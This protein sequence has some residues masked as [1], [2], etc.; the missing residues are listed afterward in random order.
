MRALAANVRPPRRAGRIVRTAAA[1]QLPLPIRLGLRAAT[2]RPGRFVANTLGLSISIAMVITGLALHAGV[3]KHLRRGPSLARAQAGGADDPD[4]VSLAATVA[5]FDRLSTLVFACA[6]F[7]LG[8]AAVNAAVAAV[9]AA[10]DSARNHAILRTIGVTPRQTAAAFLVA[11]LA[12]CLLA[13]AIGIPF[14]VTL[15]EVSR[16]VL[17]PIALSPL[18]Y[19]TVI[20]A[21]PLLY[22]LIAAT[23][24]RLL[25]R[26]PIAPQLTYE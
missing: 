16:G 11:H 25:A 20:V 22:A 15:F 7:L 6:A 12:A 14:G 9:F 8:L 13:C 23:P 19:A 10:R 17:D 2:R 5:E 21:A 18:T 24:A 3:Q 1:L 26:Q 4:P